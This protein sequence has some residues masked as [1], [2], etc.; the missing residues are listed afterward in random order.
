MVFMAVL[1]L[2]WFVSQV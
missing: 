2:L 1:C